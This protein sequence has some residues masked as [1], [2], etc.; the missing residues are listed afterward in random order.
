MARAQPCLALQHPFPRSSE[1]GIPSKPPAQRE[2]R[3]NI[4]GNIMR[5]KRL[6]GAGVSCKRVCTIRSNEL[7]RSSLHTLHVR[8]N[9][10]ARP[11]G[12]AR[13]G[14]TRRQRDRRMTDGSTERKPTLY[15]RSARSRH[16]L[17]EARPSPA[18]IATLSHART[19]FGARALAS[20]RDDHTLALRGAPARGSTLEQR[21]P[22][23][24]R[25]LQS[26]QSEIES[27]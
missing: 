2:R 11:H 12:N 3:L 23:A 8:T 13:S 25:W 14:K 20:C 24:L 4:S 7:L 17:H 16:G 27:T 1:P 15:G 6:V 9:R 26:V 21:L 19:R 18:T 10:A 22:A 5:R